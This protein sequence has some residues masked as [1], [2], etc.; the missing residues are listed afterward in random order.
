MA[1]GTLSLIQVAAICMSPDTFKL[2]KTQEDK[3]PYFYHIP[4]YMK[5]QRQPLVKIW[6]LLFMGAALLS[7]APIYNELINRIFSLMT[8]NLTAFPYCFTNQAQV[9][10]IV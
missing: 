5:N 7:I 10:Q 8:S 3:P 1:L 2:S 9:F 4:T 6:K